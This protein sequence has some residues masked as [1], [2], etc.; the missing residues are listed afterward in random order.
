[1]C[2]G[3]V[4]TGVL[5]KGITCLAVFAGLFLLTKYSY[6]QKHMSHWIGP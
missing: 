2:D 6:T 5:V 4:N 1:M 3:G